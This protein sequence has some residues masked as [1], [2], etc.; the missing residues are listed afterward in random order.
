VAGKGNNGGDGFVAARHLA[1]AGVRT[2]VYFFGSPRELKNEPAL[3]RRILLRMG[4]PVR[5]PPAGPKL[6]KELKSC[7]I[8]ID[9]L[10]GTGL[11]REMRGVGL[12]AVR[13]INGSG[14]PVLSVDVPSG[15][16]ADSGR[17]IGG[18]GACVRADAT[19]TFGLP[20]RGFRAPGA[21][22]Y[23]GRVIVKRISLPRA[24]LR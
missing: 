15:L 19:V 21:G 18:A 7:D 11:T 24:L 1:N 10:Y 4:V 2:R 12:A 13:A 5:R 17:P 3:N 23:T 9:A 20:K 8:I 14:R 6:E 22:A 16:G